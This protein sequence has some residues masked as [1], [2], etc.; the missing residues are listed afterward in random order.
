MHT[1]QLDKLHTTKDQQLLNDTRAFISRFWAPPSEAALDLLTLW[2]A[3][4]HAV[5]GESNRLVFETTQRLFLCSTGPQSGKSTALEMLELLSG[6]PF[7]VADPTAPALLTLIDQERASLLIDELDTLM[8]QGA[9]G[10]STRTIMLEGYSEGGR[11]PRKES[12]TTRMVSC[13]A[14]IGLRRHAPELHVQPEAG[15]RWGG[16]CMRALGCVCS[17]VWTTST[18]SKYASTA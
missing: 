10:R 14:P 9:G 7:R 16:C 2:L 13:F 15:Q 6:R 3:H 5:D 1:T 4:T 18:T 8:G 17:G 12:G 11:V